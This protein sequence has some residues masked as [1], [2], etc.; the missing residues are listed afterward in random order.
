VAEHVYIRNV[1]QY[2]GQ[3]VTIKGW[4][5]NKRDKGKLQFLLVRDGTGII[6]AVAF[7][8]E[9]N[10]EAFAAATAATQESSLIVTGVV[11][12]DSRAP[13]G[14][15]L[16]LSDCQLVQL[17]QDYPIT[18]KE[19]GIDFLMDHRH[20]WLRSSQQWAIMRVRATVIRA[21]RDWL[22]NHDFMLVDAPILTPSACEGTSNLFETQ[23]FDE[24]AYLTQ[25][26]QLYNE[27]TIMAFGRTYCF[28]PTFRAEKSK[29]RRH[30]IEF[31]M[32][33]PEMA[34]A[35]LEECLRVE[36]EFV[37]Y[38]V[39]RALEVNA[40]ELKILERDTTKLASI[41]PPFPRISYTDALELLKR[42]GEELP[43][44]EDLG[45]P[46]ETLIASSYDKPVFVHRYPAR[47]KAFYMEADPENEQL[48]LSADLLAPEGY[49][50]II[51]G[52]QRTASLALLEQRIA[53]H[54]LPKEAFEWY[55][56]LRRYGTVPHAGFGLG[57]ERTVTWICGLPHIRE[58]IPFPRTLGRIYP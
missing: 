25:S 2:A 40:E 46:H 18:P 3:T 33:E 49:G 39:Q 29:T 11:R 22:D 57:V 12:P 19:H 6:Q 45:A 24:K 10:A 44:G 26:G 1:A 23:Y 27:A 56:D 35:D 47:C 15:E 32:V 55:L 31:W 58:T 53:E 5:Y 21:I 16:S 8:N 52:G 54:N 17:T 36:Q 20:L 38:I 50:E 4:L 30:L 14:F 43:W 48:S 7:R 9:I 51:G 37:S 34:Y 28:G 41:A 13:G 42:G